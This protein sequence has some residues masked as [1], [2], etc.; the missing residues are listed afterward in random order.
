MVKNIYGQTK[1]SA[2]PITV[3]FIIA[4]S[5]NFSCR[6]RCNRLCKNNRE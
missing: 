4:A 3:S 5:I 2:L 6:I 1:Y